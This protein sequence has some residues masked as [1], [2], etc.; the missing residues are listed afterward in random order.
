MGEGLISAVIPAYNYG[1]YVTE[2]VDSVLAQTYP[3]I[4]VIV[5]D[6]GSTDDTRERLAPYEDRIRYIYQANKGLSAARNT[7]IRNARGKWV[8]LLDADDV[9]HPRKTEVQLKATEALGDLGLIGSPKTFEMPEVLPP[10]PEIQRLEV[11]DFLTAAPFGPSAV[12]V[13]RD[14]FDEVG[15][16][17]E[18]LTSIEDRDMWLRLAARYPA[19]VVKSP[20]W[21]YRHHDGQMSRRA[22]RM[23]Q[24]YRSVLEKFFRSQRSYKHLKGQAWGYLYYDASWSFLQES[25]RRTALVYLLKS[26][27]QW[28]WPLGHVHTTIRWPRVKLLLRAAIGDGV[29]RRLAS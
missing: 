23:Y 29:F 12:L 5:V 16:F 4:E 19:A 24:N 13:R 2:A 3:D 20:C 11:R 15:L 14:C 25:E 7:G 18:S 9:W 8:A 22:A 26:L 27:Y 21:K 10:D 28:P 17:D 1:R 6:D